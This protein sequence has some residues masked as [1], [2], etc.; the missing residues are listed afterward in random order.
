MTPEVIS[1]SMAWRN[2][3]VISPLCSTLAGTSLDY[4]AILES[5]IAS[6]MWRC[7]A[8]SRGKAL[9]MINLGERALL[10]KL[11]GPGLWRSRR[12]QW[13][14]W[15][16]RNFGHCCS[17]FFKGVHQRPYAS[18]SSEIHVRSVDLVNIPNLL[19]KIS[20]GEREDHLSSQGLWT[21]K[22][23][24][25][26]PELLGLSCMLESPGDPPRDSE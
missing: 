13:L 24:I 15:K 18:A 8:R 22:L 12:D 9:K 5:L 1:K 25:F 21:L 4:V 6:D 3:D 7:W 2:H 11:G 20:V 17:I 16:I 23:R 19:N 10:T 26:V 14:G